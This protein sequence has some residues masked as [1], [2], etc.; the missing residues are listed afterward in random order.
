ME[1][2]KIDMKI[3]FEYPISNWSGFVGSEG[4]KGGGDVHNNGDFAFGFIMGSSF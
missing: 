1:K 4:D 2:E 3:K